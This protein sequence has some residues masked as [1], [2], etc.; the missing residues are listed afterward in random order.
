MSE[1]G[2]EV[3][4]QTK[5]YMD[6]SDSV[7]K[8]VRDIQNAIHGREVRGALAAGV[9]KSFSKSKEAKEKSEEAI[10]VTQDILDESFDS[11]ALEGNFKER[12]DDEIQNLQPEWTKFKEDTDE[13][14][15]KV[16]SQLAQETQQR[17]N[18]INTLENDMRDSLAHK[19]DEIDLKTER[20][21]IDN[22]I[23]NEGDTEGNS[24]LIDIRAGVG[25]KVYDSAGESVRAISRGEAIYNLDPNNF[26]EKYHV[27][28]INLL[29][30]ERVIENTY[31]NANGEV[32]PRDGYS[33]LEIDVE[34]GK[35]YR[36]TRYDDDTFEIIPLSGRY[37]FF[38]SEDNVLETDIT[39]SSRIAPENAVILRK[40][41]STE[42]YERG[43]VMA[44]LGS[45]IPNEYEPYGAKAIKSDI[46]DLTE[47]ENRLT[48]LENNPPLKKNEEVKLTVN[49]YEGIDFNTAN[50]VK[51][52][53]H[54]HTTNSTDGQA[55]PQDVVDRYAEI[56]FDALAITDHNRICY[57]WQFASSPL[58]AERTRESW[59]D[60]DPEQVGMID[61]PGNEVN[62]QHHI[63]ILWKNDYEE[64]PNYEW[65]RNTPEATLENTY[66][67]ETKVEPA[68]DLA[69]QDEG[70]EENPK[71]VAYFTHPSRYWDPS[72]TDYK[73]GEDYSLQWYLSWFKR[74]SSDC[75][76]GIEVFND[77]D[78]YPDDRILW[79]MLLTHLM[80]ERTV[81]GLA[82]DD[83]H[84]NGLYGIRWS[85]VRFLV[86]GEVT[87]EKLREAMVKGNFYSTY[88]TNRTTTYPQLTGVYIDEEN[89]TITLNTDKSD[90]VI[91][92]SGYEW[93]DVE[94]K[95]ISKVVGN[96]NTF[97]YSN[98]GGNYVRAEIVESETRK[99]VVQ[100]FGFEFVEV[101]EE[102][103]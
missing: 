24:E 47:I 88:T 7:D 94:G 11:A 100:P 79:D 54:T 35:S 43:G 18:Q 2:K 71:A 60:R 41:V 17:Q 84:A 80:P 87:K 33:L 67:W 62:G 64:R 3:E 102:E 53:L 25:G 49:P 45:T 37:S 69:A 10:E 15:G 57:N 89:K 52:N 6:D 12:L 83:Y 40:H 27:K 90:P 81:L 31:L 56:G 76:L 66:D 21:R 36:F 14:F 19:A 58:W 13:N 63:N 39:S 86:N 93:D 74:Y 8:E 77:D 30:P 75:L 44:I 96:G 23:A 32:F 72:K 22:L 95:Y 29:N 82:G 97:N 46:I 28:S 59:E 1:Y 38:D 9:K 70:T 5:T 99:T 101:E 85:V 73:D 51:T 65:R 91:W 55:L 48:N 68:L 78:K 61:I 42:R 20:G 92:Y 26:D 103:E 98:F 34:P 50:V 4:Q 16:E